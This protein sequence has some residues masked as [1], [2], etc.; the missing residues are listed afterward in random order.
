MNSFFRGMMSIFGWTDVFHD[1]SP[2]KRI[3]EI[4]DEFYADHPWIERNDQKALINDMNT[5][6]ND[7]KDLYE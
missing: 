5:I 6:A 4:L 7:Y 3:E 2:K 1:L